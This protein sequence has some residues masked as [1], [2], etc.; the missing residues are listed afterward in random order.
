MSFEW[1]NQ[2]AKLFSWVFKQI[3]INQKWTQ[4]VLNKKARYLFAELKP[5]ILDT[6][7]Y[8]DNMHTLSLSS[9]LYD[10]SQ[11]PNSSGTIESK[12]IPQSQK[13]LELN[14]RCLIINDWFYIFFDLLR[15]DSRTE[16]LNSLI[17]KVNNLNCLFRRLESEVI[18]D[19]KVLIDEI[20][21]VPVTVKRNYPVT[22]DGLNQFFTD[23]EKF[24][25]KCQRELRGAVT[26]MSF[27]RLE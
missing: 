5:M 11:T 8:F 22:R 24:L 16:N 12:L 18:R 6:K 4:W 9:I 10:V 20:G 7:D 1:L 27:E 14:R 13:F 23:Y 26:A 3:R 19:F 17:V 25:K 21:G 2:L 15:R